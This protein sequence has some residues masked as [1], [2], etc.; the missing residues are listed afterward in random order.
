MTIANSC[1]SIVALPFASLHFFEDMRRELSDSE[2][3][4]QLCIVA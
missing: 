1:M 3:V 2:N 4:G